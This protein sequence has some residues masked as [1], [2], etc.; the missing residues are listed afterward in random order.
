MTTIYLIGVFWFYSE[1]YGS[2]CLHII[3]LKGRLDER[4]PRATT[5]RNA[6]AQ[7]RAESTTNNESTPQDP[8]TL[9]FNKAQFE[10][11]S[12]NFDLQQYQHGKIN[13]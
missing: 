4:S 5:R 1:T 8:T 11:F 10:L 9:S 12:P 13:V 3:P 6:R 2:K 7:R